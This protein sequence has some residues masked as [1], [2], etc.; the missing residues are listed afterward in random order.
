MATM[1]FTVPD[2]VRDRFE[3]SFRD[4]DHSVVVTGLLLLAV[5]A[6]ERERRR[7]R[8]LL[9][10]LRRVGNASAR[11]PLDPPRR[12]AQPRD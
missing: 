5:E 1:R 4:H 8:S 12:A 2:E 3:Q 9:E 10:R 11:P 7:S 6:E